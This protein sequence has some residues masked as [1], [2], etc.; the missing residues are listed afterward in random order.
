MEFVEFLDRELVR[1]TRFA[2]VLV[3]NRQD[4]HDVL[5]DALLDVGKQ[6]SRI[7]ELD[8]PTAYVRK[9]IVNRFL[10]DRRKFYRRRTDV[11]NDDSRLDRVVDDGAA[12][13][14][15]RDLLDRLLRELPPRRRAV[16]VLR[17]YLGLDDG[18]IAAELGHLLPHPSPAPSS[19]AS[20]RAGIYA[21]AQELV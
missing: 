2:G 4:A 16:I 8:H 3:G 20:L 18:A 7:S 5:A 21:A 6:W 13:V 15:N 10:A 1:L 11:T 14:A 12:V 19:P 17:Y 9:V